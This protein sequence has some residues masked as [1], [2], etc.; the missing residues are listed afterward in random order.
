MRQMP[1]LAKRFAA[2]AV[3]LLSLAIIAV[4]GLRGM[5]F[6][7]G[8]GPFADPTPEV[9]TATPDPCGPSP[10]VV[11]LS[12]CGEIEQQ[13]SNLRELPAADIGPPEIP[14]RAAPARVL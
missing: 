3:L 9:A 2:L 14:T 8:C 1:P 5:G 10:S 11:A 7:I 13:V 6:Q 12:A 4:L